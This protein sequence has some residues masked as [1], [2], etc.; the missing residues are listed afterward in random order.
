M[1][2]SLKTWL[3][4]TI[5]TSVGI[6]LGML[7]ADKKSRNKPQQTNDKKSTAAR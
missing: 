5:S 4:A 2:E 3:V 7:L 1:K 6:A